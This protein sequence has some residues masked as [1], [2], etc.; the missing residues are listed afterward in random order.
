VGW[1]KLLFLCFLCQGT[2]VSSFAQGNNYT[3]ADLNSYKSHLDNTAADNTGKLD[4]KIQKDYKKIIADK[5]TA[6]IKQ[7][8]EKGFLFDAKAY[9]YL[10]T[11]F[12]HILEK[13]SLDK[14]Q[15]HFF[16]DR[17]PEVNAYS[18]EDGTVVCNL[19]LVTVMENE[20][21]LAMVFCHELGHCLLKHSNNAIIKQLEKYNSPEFAA[22]I[23]AIKRQNYNVN[24]QL[25]GLLLTDFFDR[26]KHTRSQEW[27]AD[28][29]GMILFSKTGYSGKN[30]SRLFDLLDSADHKTNACTVSS[31]FQ[32]EKIDI[33]AGL[34]RPAK[35]MSFGSQSK[36]MADSLK[37]HPDCANRKVI[38]QAWFDQHPKTG[39]DFLLSNEEQLEKVKKIA[40][41]EEA[42]YAKDSDIYGFYLF[43]LIENDALFP[44]N[45]AIKTSIFDALVAVCTH[46]KKHTLYEI[47]S[48]PYAPDSDND[49]YAKLLKL[50]NTAD[51]KKMIEI[52]DIYYQNNKPLIAAP[53]ETIN[54][55]NTLNN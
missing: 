44:S 34:L 12:N 7:L 28:S 11:I 2:W 52:T 5:N 20:S 41:F 15:F 16:I 13:N 48:S 6:I 46:E 25:E 1:I 32:R 14:S 33:D 4:Q 19:G 50:L 39:A 26:R 38:M 40:F 8:N 24:K 3:Y 35:K 53:K 27:A 36:G 10:S 18:Y 29:L 9:P 45:G 30:V 43:R 21:Q 55:Y 31:F 42:A 49:E 54:D 51:L 17:S 37:T 23:K 47:V 22:K